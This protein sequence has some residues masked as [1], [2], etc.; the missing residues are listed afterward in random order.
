LTAQAEKTNSRNNWKMNVRWSKS[1]EAFCWDIRVVSN[2]QLKM[3][4]LTVCRLIFISSISLIM[5]LVLQHW[6]KLI[7]FIFVISPDQKIHHGLIHSFSGQNLICNVISTSPHS[8]SSRY[9]SCA[10]HHGPNDQWKGFIKCSVIAILNN[11]TLIIP[12]LFPHCQDKTQE[13]QWFED[14]YDLEQLAQ[15]LKF[16]KLKQFIQQTVN[17]DNKTMMDCYMLQI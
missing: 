4:K 11:F 3:R 12:P 6:Y 16:V 10:N 1:F 2:V 17:R 7:K 14:F 15:A 5:M 9:L 8:H 13:I